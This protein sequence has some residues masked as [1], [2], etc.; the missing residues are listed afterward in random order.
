MSWPRKILP[1]SL[2]SRL[3]LSFGILIFLSLFLAGS[4]T[5]FLL[6]DQQQTAA[7]ERV[8]LLTDEVTLRAFVLEASGLSAEAIQAT[9]E[10]E[11]NVR[12]LLVSGNRVVGD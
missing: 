1:R 5:F 8:G 3:I 7:R 10:E 11:Y 9:L 6:R 2:R 12:I 4:A